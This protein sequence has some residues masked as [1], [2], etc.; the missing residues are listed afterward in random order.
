MKLCDFEGLYTSFFTFS[1]LFAMR[2]QWNIGADFSMTS[3]E[4]P[5]NALLYFSSGEGRY[6]GRN[7]ELICEAEKG[8]LVYIPK[9]SRYTIEFS[10]TSRTET[11]LLEFLAFGKDGEELIMSNNIIRLF[12]DT[13]RCASDFEELVSAYCVPLP[14]QP[15]VQSLTY[16]LFHDVSR[17]ALKK[18]YAE[19]DF[20]VIAKGI[21]KIE[22]STEQ[23]ENVAE[24][25]RECGVS[26]GTFNS[27]CLKYCGMP[28]GAYRLH[29]RLERAKGLLLRSELNVSE[30]AS[31]LGF[32][33]TGYFCRFFKRSTGMT[34]SEWRKGAP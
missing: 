16:R 27:L 32:E 18:S 15:L 14:S 2:Q 6:I 8:S 3:H 23:Q 19:S 25:A 7:S 26:V 11:L 29:L 22:N 10:R 1:R 30:V 5:T 20:A 33:D 13:G 28:P 21:S 12:G 31:A 9:G 34:P 17:R 4:R 24:L